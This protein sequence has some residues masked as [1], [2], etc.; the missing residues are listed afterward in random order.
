MPVET[1]EVNGE[2]DSNSLILFYL[3]ELVLKLD[4]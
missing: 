3:D 2:A 1:Q 4:S